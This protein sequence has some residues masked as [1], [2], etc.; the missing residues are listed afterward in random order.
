[1]PTPLLHVGLQAGPVAPADLPWDELT[2]CGAEAQFVGRTRAQTHPEHGALL[3]LDYEAYEPMAAR[4]LE[5]FAREAAA[6]HGAQAVRVLHSLGAVPVGAASVVIQVASGHRAESF[7]ACRE[8]IER[9]KHE[10][11]VWKAEVWERGRTFAPGQPV[12]SA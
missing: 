10:L 7:S 2:A 1:M 4:L 9:I 11:P 3:A 5:Q 8:V 12:T 6:R